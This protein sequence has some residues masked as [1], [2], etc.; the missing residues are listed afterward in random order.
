MTDSTDKTQVILS[1]SDLEILLRPFR[2]LGIS[3]SETQA[4]WPR[5]LY[6]ALSGLKGSAPRNPLEN[7]RY[8]SKRSR[9]VARDEVFFISFCGV[10]K[11]VNKRYGGNRFRVVGRPHFAFWSFVGRGMRWCFLLFYRV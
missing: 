11:G 10:W 2:A 4:L 5:L 1:T 8:T 6:I 9:I 7:E 3:L